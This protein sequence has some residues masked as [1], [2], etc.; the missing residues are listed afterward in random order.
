[1]VQRFRADGILFVGTLV[2]K[3]EHVTVT[4]N[5]QS[6]IRV[7]PTASGGAESDPAAAAGAGVAGV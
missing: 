4:T 1:M 3:V 5:C 2:G 6:G 7:G